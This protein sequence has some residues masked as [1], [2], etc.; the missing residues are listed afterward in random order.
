MPGSCKMRAVE[1]AQ[2]QIVEAVVI[3]ARQPRRPRAVFPYPLP[4]SIF[5]LLLLFARRDGLLLIDDPRSVLPLVVSGRHAAIER[6]VDQ[7]GGAEPRRAVRRGVGDAVL[8]AGIDLDR[9][10]R[11]GSGVR[12]AH[13]A[14]RDVEQ[15]GDEVPDVGRRNPRRPQAGLDVARLQIG[16]L[17]R[18]Q[19]LD[20]P[21]VSRVE[22]RRRR[23][24]RQ[25]AAHVAAQ[26]AV[27]GFPLPALRI[28]PDKSF[29]AR[30]ATPLRGGLSPAPCAATGYR[31]SH[32][33]KRRALPP[34]S[35]HARPGDSAPVSAARRWPSLWHASSR[36]RSFRG[37]V[38]G[39]DRD[40]RR[41][42]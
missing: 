16:G 8:L 7:L 25:L 30:A 17:H 42:P 28:A 11:D 19:R 26:I 21:R 23:G 9:P 12:H 14:R 4:E 33:G 35:R 39:A 3:F 20:I 18:L 31:R 40:R 41:R 13:A 5:Q 29:P 34:P 36:D 24:C 38:T 22:R 27:G 2:A 6:L 1:A 37:R 32:S 15:R 10:G